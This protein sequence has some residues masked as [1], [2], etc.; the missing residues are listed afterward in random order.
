MS[1]EHWFDPK[2]PATP[3]QAAL[4]L[5]GINP[6]HFPYAEQ[7]RAEEAAETSLDALTIRDM[8]SGK[9]VRRTTVSDA[10][11]EMRL[12]FA[13]VQQTDP[14]AS[15][16]MAQWLEIA[17]T[18]GLVNHPWVEAWA[19]AVA[20][21][22][23]STS[24]HMSQNNDRDLASSRSDASQPVGLAI[25]RNSRESIAAH[26]KERSSELYR[27]DKSLTKEKISQAIATELKAK[28]YSGERSQYLTA[29]TIVRLM[30]AGLT[31][32]RAKNGKKS[33]GK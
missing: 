22:A 4:V 21:I 25:G 9:I 20:Q 5:C 29:T 7:H 33:P 15:R 30:P 23:R 26:V 10:Y 31:G 13:G 1:A 27:A 18:R 12:V 28:G 24:D 3:S 19:E 11:R 17:K 14:T 8:A 2:Q 6:Q 32:G 16:T